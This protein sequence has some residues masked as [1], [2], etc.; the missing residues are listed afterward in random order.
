MNTGA[1]ELG[2]LLLGEVGAKC[3][4][5]DVASAVGQGDG[6]G[7]DRVFHNYRGRPAESWSGR[8]PYSCALLWN[9]GVSPSLVPN[10]DYHQW[11]AL[12]KAA[13]VRDARL[14]D[15]RHTAATALLI[16]RVPRADGHGTHGVVSHGLEG[17]AASV[18][19]KVLHKKRPKLILILD[20]EAIFGACMNPKW[21][22]R[23][24]S[25]DCVYAKARIARRLRSAHPC[26]PQATHL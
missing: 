7:I 20:N 24:A 23:L 10:S 26:V 8:T 21:P 25:T 3:S 11:K 17:F 16:L 1:G 4:D 19:T 13:G 14:H 22:E 9:S 2:C 5:S 6:D 15:A 12:L 18:A